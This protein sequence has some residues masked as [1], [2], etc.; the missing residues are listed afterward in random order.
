VVEA[1]CFLILSVSAFIILEQSFVGFAKK[2]RP[3][4]NKRNSVLRKRLKRGVS[5]S[6]TVDH[7]YLRRLSKQ[8][9]YEKG[10]RGDYGE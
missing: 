4:D 3:H 9:S 6:S 8:N 10:L 5:C 7:H 2:T 1:A